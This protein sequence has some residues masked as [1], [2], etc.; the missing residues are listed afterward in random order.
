MYLRKADLLEE[1]KTEAKRS[2]ASLG[3]LSPKSTIKN[4]VNILKTLIRL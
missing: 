1:R 4:I 3:R 2:S